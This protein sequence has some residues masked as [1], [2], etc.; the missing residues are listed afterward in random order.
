[1]TLS[2]FLSSWEATCFDEWVLGGNATQGRFPKEVTD[3][4]GKMHGNGKEETE[5]NG[6]VGKLGK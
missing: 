5:R 1:M 6:G 3:S 2:L 4:R